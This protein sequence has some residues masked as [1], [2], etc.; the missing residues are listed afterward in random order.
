MYMESAG[1]GER[2][3]AQPAAPGLLPPTPSLYREGDG[4]SQRLSCQPEATEARDRA[5]AWSRGAI[6]ISE[7]HLP[8]NHREAA[9]ETPKDATGSRPQ[10]LPWRCQ[11]DSGVGVLCPSLASCVTLGKLFN[12]SVPYF[13]HLV[14]E[15]LA[16]PTSR[17]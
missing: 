11:V 14:N 4:G 13:S 15:I 8:G 7:G 3:R 1:T 5:E 9:A 10:S 6:C 17:G 12:F 16:T 2:Q